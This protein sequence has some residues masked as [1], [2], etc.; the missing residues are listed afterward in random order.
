MHSVLISAV[1]T[2]LSL[3]ARPQQFISSF[4]KPFYDLEIGFQSS[5]KTTA[6]FPTWFLANQNIQKPGKSLTNV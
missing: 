6:G 4:L 1:L 5:F 3:S 2:A